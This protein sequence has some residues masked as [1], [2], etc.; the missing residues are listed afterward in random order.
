MKANSLKSV[1]LSGI[2][3]R[4]S[5]KVIVLRLDMYVFPAWVKLGSYTLTFNDPYSR[6][7]YSGVHFFK[8]G[9]VDAMSM[10]TTGRS[11]SK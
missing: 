5:P 2:R 1:A 7:K 6:A 4:Y 3:F 11:G 8:A 9:H 10:S